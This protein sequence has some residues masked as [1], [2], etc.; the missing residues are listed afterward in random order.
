MVDA[1]NGNK[2]CS[3]LLNC[4]TVLERP[5]QAHRTVGTFPNQPSQ[6]STANVIAAGRK[7]VRRKR[8]SK[9]E[10]SGISRV[11][12]PTV[13]DTK[14][15]SGYDGDIEKEAIVGKVDKDSLM[16]QD[17]YLGKITFF[18]P[19]F[20]ALDLILYEASPELTPSWYVV[21]KFFFIFTIVYLCN[22]IF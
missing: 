21:C 20:Y 4:S 19:L 6:T 11:L 14:E 15:M 9:V 16:P 7:K 13:S 10:L 18:T 3:E 2:L 5:K 22:C 1:S 12:Y 17:S 8:L